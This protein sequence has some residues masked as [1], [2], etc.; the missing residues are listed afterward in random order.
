MEKHGPD[1][2]LISLTRHIVKSLKIG[3][4]INNTDKYNKTERDLKY[5]LSNQPSQ[6]NKKLFKDTMITCQFA[7]TTEEN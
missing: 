5:M 4:R 2:C 7:I 3:I 6:M 1:C